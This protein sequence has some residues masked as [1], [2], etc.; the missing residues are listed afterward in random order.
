M[1]VNHTELPIEGTETTTIYELWQVSETGS[2]SFKSSNSLLE[3]TTKDR[4]RIRKYPYAS[5]ST[6][7]IFKRSTTTVTERVVEQHPV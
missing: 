4:E 1:K 6:F 7:E 3:R 2:V 5:Q